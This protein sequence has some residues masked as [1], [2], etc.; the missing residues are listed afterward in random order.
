MVEGP[1][2]KPDDEAG[3]GAAEPRGAS[4][5]ATVPAMD[6]EESPMATSRPSNEP[7]SSVVFAT[8]PEA[9]AAWTAASA[10]PG[11]RAPNGVHNECDAFCVF[12]GV[13][14]CGNGNSGCPWWL[15]LE[16]IRLWGPLL[17][18]LGSSLAPRV[19]LPVLLLPVLLPKLLLLLL[20]LVVEVVEGSNVR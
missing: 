13:G 17:L 10:S 20:L 8:L 2:R 14:L 12:G 1:A 7:G 19:V 4:G 5:A 18:V 16:D 6:G 15:L 11:L 9:A 3:G